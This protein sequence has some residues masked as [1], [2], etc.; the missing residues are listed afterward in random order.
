MT[1]SNVVVCGLPERCDT[2]NQQ[3]SDE[4]AFNRLCEEHLSVKPSLSQKGCKRL[5][6]LTATEA[7]SL[8]A[9]WF[10]SHLKKMCL[11]F[12]QLQSV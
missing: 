5:G 12:S 1:S 7:I 9:Y 6:K 2:T 8:G 11:I 10:I 3:Q 4:A